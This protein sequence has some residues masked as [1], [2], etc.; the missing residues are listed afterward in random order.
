MAED[1]LGAWAAA[2]GQEEAWAACTQAPEVEVARAAAASRAK[3]AVLA[4]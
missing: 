4:A 1:M 2:M 3:I